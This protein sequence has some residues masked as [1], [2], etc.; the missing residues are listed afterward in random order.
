[1]KHL[2]FL[3]LFSVPALAQKTSIKW[4]DD[5][6]IQT[7]SEG[8]RP[9]KAKKNYESHPLKVNKLSFQRGVGA[10]SP[11]VL[12]FNLD[13]KALR[14]QA[15]IGNDDEGNPALS[16]SYYVLG[17]GKILFE[18]KNMKMGDNPIAIDVS[19]KGIKQLGLLVLDTVGGINNKRTYANWLDARV[20]MIENSSI[21]YVEN[22]GK[23]YILTPKT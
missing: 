23:K 14:F 9:V 16:L 19:L 20:E 6:E 22:K 1:M 3:L 18:K 10:Q 21:G 4:L 5:L 12:A 2:L 11:C 15:K 13:K 17:D 7:F 8:L